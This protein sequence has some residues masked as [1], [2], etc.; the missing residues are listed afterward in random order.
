[1][2]IAQVVSTYP[3]YRGGMGRVAF[4]YTERLRARGHDVHV[5]TPDAPG[6][7]DEDPAHV[8]RLP[9]LLRVGNAALTPALAA[10]VAGFDLVHLHYPFF[11]GAEP[12]A[13][14]RFFGPPTPM[15][16]TYQMD[17]TAG[18]ARGAFFRLHERVVLP[19]IVRRARRVLASSQDYFEASALAAVAGAQDRLEVLPHGVDLARFHP[20]DDPDRRREAVAGGDEPVVLF[21]GGLDRAHDFKGLP[22][23]FDALAGL[24]HRPWRLVVVGDG[25]RRAAF[26]ADARARG[27]ASRI[28]F[29]GDVAD[30]DLPGI[31]RAADLHVLPST[32]QAEAFGLVTLEAASSGIPSIVS[33][34]PGL[35]TTVVDGETGLIA[36]PADSAAL[37]RAIARLIDGPDERQRMGA[38]ARQRVLREHDWE[39]IIGRLEDIYRNQC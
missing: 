24:L 21:V 17:A 20:H 39:P 9:A 32:S 29:V 38:A 27:L 35:R 1:M 31:Y 26:E 37:A 7:S 33:D 11:G 10:A 4:E 15:V 3:P 14:H 18:G 16:L 30:V 8:H 28:R 22:V 13:L 12:V 19:W 25:D 2:R 34:L 5:F 36:P 23:L 6:R